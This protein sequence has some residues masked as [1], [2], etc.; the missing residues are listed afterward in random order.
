MTKTILTM[1]LLLFTTGIQ[2][3]M[4]WQRPVVNYNRHTYNA[5]NQNWMVAQHQNG[6]MYFANNKGLLE[7]DGIYWNLYPLPHATK[8]RSIKIGKDNRIYV[9][10]LKEFGFFTDNNQGGLQYHSLSKTLTPPQTV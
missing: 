5:A 9:G 7:F 8:M 1:L 10:G 4:F 3:Q 2:A 6:W